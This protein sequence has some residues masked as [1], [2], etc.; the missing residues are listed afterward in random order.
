M[1][2]IN[3]T[4]AGQLNLQAVLN[5]A[6]NVAITESQSDSLDP[7]WFFAF[8]SMAEEIYS[9]PMQ[10]LWGRIFAVE[11]SKPGSF[12]LR[13]LQLL[14]SLTHRDAQIF[15]KA[16]SMACRRQHD[17]VPRILVG[18][19][20]RRGVLSFLGPSAPQQINLAKMGL[21]YPDLLALQDM[22]LLYASEIESGEYEQGQQ[23]FWRCGN[24]SFT[25]EANR[26][27]VALVYYKFTA[28]GSELAKL[29]SRKEN[30]AYLPALKERLSNV[31]IVT[32]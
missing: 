30:S 11:V 27:G 5:I 13:S 7:D 17:N 18:Y 6:L 10:E 14:K 16:V 23:I 1:I 29:V 21:S 24:E 4:R 25:L 20:K 28:V 3:S 8:S 15:S 26:S 32:E 31:F 2:L 22:K 19:H 12:S 9:Q